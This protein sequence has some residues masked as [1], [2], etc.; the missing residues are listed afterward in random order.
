MNKKYFLLPVF[1]FVNLT[2]ALSQHLMNNDT[3]LILSKIEASSY[4]IGFEYDIHGRVISET[5]V[6]DNDYLN[7]FFEYVYDENDNLIL[8]TK[9]D[10][11]FTSQEENE[12]NDNNQIVKKKFY[13]DYGSGFKFV[14]QKLYTYQEEYL[15]T[16]IQQMV[17]GN[18]QNFYNN[19]KQEFYYDK[20]DLLYQ[21]KQYA[22][23]SGD[24]QENELFDYE[25]DDFNYLLNYTNGFFIGVDFYNSWRYN[26]QYNDAYELTERGYHIPL[27]S[28]WDS[29][30]L[31][32]TVYY[33]EPL[34]ESEV[35]LYPNVYQFDELNFNLFQPNDKKLIKID[36]WDSSCGDPL[37]YVESAHYEYKTLILNPDTVQSVNYYKIDD[38]TIYPNP[39]TG[40]LQITNYEL[41]KGTNPL[42]IEIF[43]IFGRK[44][45]FGFAQQPSQASRVTGN[46][47]IDISHLKAGIYFVR[48]Q[49]KI[50]IITRK[51]IKVSSPQIR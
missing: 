46:M 51:I 13:Q 17:T 19:I 44:Q 10:I 22:Y 24:W 26:F 31:R 45:C 3:V 12:Y 14:E 41:S 5:K 9:S 6:A 32:K 38:I 27:G 33:F 42:V 4:S 1:L 11:N 34:T 40:E 2:V 15:E 16:I 43:D 8:I 21:I 28:G 7:Y 48:V 29:R 23:I 37:H 20:N 39:T 49:T 18:G 50:G 47:I 35:V 36:F 25:Y 30:P